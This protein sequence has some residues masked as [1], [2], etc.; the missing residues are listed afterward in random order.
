MSKNTETSKTKSYTIKSDEVTI[1]ELGVKRS[2]MGE[3]DAM[4]HAH[5]IAYIDKPTDEIICRNISTQIIERTKKYKD[6]RSSLDAEYIK[7]I[8][9]LRSALNKTPPEAYKILLDEEIHKKTIEIKVKEQTADKQ[10]FKSKM[11]EIMGN[12]YNSNRERDLIDWFCTAETQAWYDALTM[13]NIELEKIYIAM[14]HAN[15][16]GGYSVRSEEYATRKQFVEKAR[17]RAGCDEL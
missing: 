4:V 5:R 9:R 2:G 17:L 11:N 6:D 1:V 7:D 10:K 16:R 15:L 13:D 14:H 3:K 12:P 8:E